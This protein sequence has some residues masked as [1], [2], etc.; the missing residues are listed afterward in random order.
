MKKTTINLSK[1]TST[2]EFMFDSGVGDRPVRIEIF[3][4]TDEA[5]VYRA[6]VW[7]INTYNLYPALLNTAANG[8]DLH[9]VHSADQINM[10]ITNLIAEQPD[11]LF[12]K[13]YPSEEEFLE[14]VKTR[15]V[16]FLQSN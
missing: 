15:V 7:M 11:I 14:Y 16:E 6:R 2:Y 5:D 4:S 10:D 3:K 9:Q 13:Q 8:K 12:G 1:L